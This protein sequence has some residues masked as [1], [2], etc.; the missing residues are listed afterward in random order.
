MFRR[1]YR[2]KDYLFY[3]LWLIVVLCRQLRG[4][5]NSQ[6]YSGFNCLY[7]VVIFL[8]VI[9]S[10]YISISG[11]GLFIPYFVFEQERAANIIF[12]YNSTLG[13]YTKTKAKGEMFSLRLIVLMTLALTGAVA[14]KLKN[15]GYE[16]IL[17]SI[18]DK[19]AY[20]SELLPKVK[21]SLACTEINYCIRF[22]WKIS[23]GQCVDTR[24]QRSGK[25]FITIF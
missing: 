1:Q 24:Q 10:Y 17:V 6:F 21:V 15:N 13:K 8:S 25:H 3:S 14:V 16:N 12:V 2:K 23:C 4:T 22:R 20:D 7:C 5:L 9:F 11:C 19:I 18:S